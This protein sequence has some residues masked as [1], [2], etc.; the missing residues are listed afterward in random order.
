MAKFYIWGRVWPLFLS[1]FP[2]ERVETLVG[3]E[4]RQ[5]LDELARDWDAANPGVVAK[6]RSAREALRR[7][8]TN[9]TAMVDLA[10]HKKRRLVNTTQIGSVTFAEVAVMAGWASAPGRIAF[11]HPEFGVYFPS[12]AVK[13]HTTE[14][15]A[16]AEGVLSALRERV[17]VLGLN[18]GPRAARAIVRYGCVDSSKLDINSRVLLAREVASRAPLLAS[19]ESWASRLATEANELA[20]L[21]ESELFDATAAHEPSTSDHSMPSGV[22][23]V[24]GMPTS[25]TNALPSLEATVIA[26]IVDSPGATVSEIAAQAGCAR[27]TLYR[28][29]RIK[30]ALDARGARKDELRR[31][32]SRVR[33]PDTRRSTRH[34]T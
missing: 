9:G 24:A 31:D 32:G 14:H 30:A 25:R 29:S 19:R 22:E 28:S 3:A 20:R 16:V 23:G 7:S 15:L 27:S 26:L 6:A 17:P 13:I 8:K 18:A 33:R 4:L 34:D 1:T 11:V 5:A 2:F 12:E 10:E 21:F